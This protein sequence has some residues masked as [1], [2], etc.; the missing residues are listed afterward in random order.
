MMSVPPPVGVCH[1]MNYN[2][3][4]GIDW[5]N[6]VIDVTFTLHMDVQAIT[7]GICIAASRSIGCMTSYA[8]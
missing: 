4:P 6:A 2:S 7:R 1:L 3:S 5:L 8:I